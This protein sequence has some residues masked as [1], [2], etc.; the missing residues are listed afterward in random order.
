MTR[1]FSSLALVAGLLCAPGFAAADFKAITTE[2]DF[3]TLVVG[4]KLKFNKDHFVIR[5]NGK[6]SGNFG[7]KALKG[8]WAWR[9]GYWCRTL[10][11]H[12]K[13]TDCQ[14]WETDGATFRVTRSKGTGQ[15]FEYT[16]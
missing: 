5:R 15:S 14:L 16:Q 9:D 8:N 10:T 2:A 12:S 4:K 1:L 6:L 13:N 7:G 3:R 11:T